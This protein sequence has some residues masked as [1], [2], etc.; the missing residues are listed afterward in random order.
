MDFSAG[1]GDSSIQGLRLCGDCKAN[2]PTPLC[3]QYR[4]PISA[5][6]TNSLPTPLAFGFKLRS[7][8][9][10]KE[11]AGWQRALTRPAAGFFPTEHQ[12]QFHAPFSKSDGGPHQRGS[13]QYRRVAGGK[14]GGKN[15]HLVSENGHE[16]FLHRLARGGEEELAALYGA[17]KRNIDDGR[18]KC[19]KSAR[20]LPRMLPVIW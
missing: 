20:H 6:V 11:P 7:G 2:A 16:I 18:E 17:T 3:R 4:L 9:Y 15:F 12:R 10:L 1:G 14:L 19:M 13:A 5:S 8:E